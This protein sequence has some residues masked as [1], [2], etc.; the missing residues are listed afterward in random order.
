MD[1]KVDDDKDEEEIGEG[2][3]GAAETADYSCGGAQASSTNRY[4][5][6]PT[7]CY[8]PMYVVSGK[9]I[10][11]LGEIPHHEQALKDGLLIEV[12]RVEEGKF[13]NKRIF[14]KERGRGANGKTKP[15]RE[16]SDTMVYFF[17][18]RWM[19][20]SLDAAL[21]HPDDEGNTKLKAIKHI[22]SPSK[23]FW[24]DY[25][26]IPQRDPRNQLR[27]IQS[28][29]YYVHAS[30]RFTALVCGAKGKEE[31]LDRAWCQ[32][33]L[34]ASKLPLRMPY[35][36]A[37]WWATPHDHTQILCCTAGEEDMTGFWRWS[38]I[39]TNFEKRPFPVWRSICLDSDHVL[40][41]T[42]RLHGRGMFRDI[43]N[44]S[45]GE[46]RLDP[47]LVSDIRDPSQCR[48]T[49]PADAFKLVPLLLFAAGELEALT[50][51]DASPNR[52]ASKVSRA[53]PVLRVLKQ[54]G[55]DC[56][57]CRH[58]GVEPLRSTRT[59]AARKGG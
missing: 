45:S 54:P 12:D 43:S 50:E 34:I 58:S 17:S 13:S 56:A 29:P 1:G 7:R 22:V 46:A 42:C 5:L 14:L 11:A 21:A 51:W 15:P 31:Y 16:V 49:N 52:A 48:L 24:I 40:L 41:E 59:R 44:E 9:A 27:A 47:I 57:G 28:L 53:A 25:M 35:W 18:H 39:Q 23:Y 6:D 8:F 32:A 2:R 19:R 10:R 33:E 55:R 30:A 26:C 37:A 3:A 4:P 36:E 20:P 38:I